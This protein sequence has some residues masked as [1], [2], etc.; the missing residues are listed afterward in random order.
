MLK[1]FPI[2]L[3]LCFMLSSSY[4][5]ENYAGIT[6]TSLMLSLGRILISNLVV[7]NLAHV[8]TSKYDSTLLGCA[9]F[10]PKVFLDETS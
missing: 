8:F 5:A 2:M 9:F 7:A 3:A 4:Y 10:T 6:N 1:N